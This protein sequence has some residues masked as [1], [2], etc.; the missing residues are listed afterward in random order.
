MRLN[1]MEVTGATDAHFLGAWC[2]NRPNG[3]AF[4]SFLPAA[5]YRPGLLDNLVLNAAVRARW[6]GDRLVELGL[7]ARPVEE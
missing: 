6:A 3:L 1:W 7:L 2:P 4:V 5:L